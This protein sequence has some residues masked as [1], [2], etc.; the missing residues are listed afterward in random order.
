M[1]HRPWIDALLASPISSGTPRF[2]EHSLLGRLAAWEIVSTGDPRAPLVRTWWRDAVACG[3]GASLAQSEAWWRPWPDV[4]SLDLAWNRV[5]GGLAWTLDALL[6]DI[7]APPETSRGLLD[8][9]RAA[10]ED[11]SG[12]DDPEAMEAEV[13]Q[14]LRAWERVVTLSDPSAPR[15]LAG[16]LH[17]ARKASRGL[18]A[19]ATLHVPLYE[20]RPVAEIV[21]ARGAVPVTVVQDAYARVVRFGAHLRDRCAER[22][23]P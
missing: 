18:R 16:R 21:R 20:V 7:P 10:L 19:P 13:E 6:D 8:A 14:L 22:F 9:A 4:V 2:L 17:A 12:Y 3:G 5:R 11:P 1:D 23:T 15:R